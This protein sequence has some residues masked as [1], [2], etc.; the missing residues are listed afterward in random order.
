MSQER[1]CKIKKTSYIIWTRNKI[2]RPAPEPGLRNFETF[3]SG[4]L[5]PHF[6]TFFHVGVDSSVPLVGLSFRPSVGVMDLEESVEI[7]EE[8]SFP[9]THDPYEG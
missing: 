8:R 9:R 7:R 1:I 2:L 5:Y 6:D 3:P 4:I